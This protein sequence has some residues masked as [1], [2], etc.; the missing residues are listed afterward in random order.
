MRACLQAWAAI[1]IQSAWRGHVVRTEIHAPHLPV[2]HSP[3]ARQVSFDDDPLGSV[4]L[5][6][7]RARQDGG[8][9]VP[10]RPEQAPSSFEDCMADKIDLKQILRRYDEWFFQKHGR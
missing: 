9:T 10:P 7:T 4:F 2:P 5:L 3:I 6:L 1:A 8:R